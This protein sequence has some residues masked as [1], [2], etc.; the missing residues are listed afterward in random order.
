MP[1]ETLMAV[2]L[3]FVIGHSAKE[4]ECFDNPHLMIEDGEI[5]KIAKHDNCFTS[6]TLQ[7]SLSERERK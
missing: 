3:T 5:R 1:S 4:N 6:D 2:W 7:I